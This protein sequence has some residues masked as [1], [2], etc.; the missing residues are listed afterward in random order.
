MSRVRRLLGSMKEI[1]PRRLALLLS[2]G[3]VLGVFPIVGVPTLLC[4]AAAFL[5][6]LNPA[7]LQG[8][9]SIT[10][11][12]QLALLLPLARIGSELCGV[13]W[14]AGNWH[15]NLGSAALCAI[16]GWACVCI[17]L[18]AVLYVAVTWIATARARR[19]AKVA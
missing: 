15:A 11:P 9:N 19:V 10:S 18:G 5:F 14:G 4:L 3:L 1:P 16:A 17:P 6:R 8:L 12:L 2:V 7:L 13:K